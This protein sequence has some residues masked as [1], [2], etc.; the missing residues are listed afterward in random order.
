MSLELG[1]NDSYINRI[2]TG[3]ALP[4]MK[5]FFC[6]CRYLCISP[7][8]FFDEDTTA[9]ELMQQID[10]ELRRLQPQQLEAILYLL[11]RME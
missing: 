8:M 6:M 10:S 5:L 11:K 2:E 4:S 3:K 9:P 7:A 1:Q